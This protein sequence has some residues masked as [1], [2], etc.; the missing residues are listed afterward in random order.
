[1]CFNQQFSYVCR[2]LA[3]TSEHSVGSGLGEEVL[4]GVWAHRH[5]NSDSESTADSD[6]A[7][8]E[9]STNQVLDSDQDLSNQLPT[10]PTELP[11]DSTNQHSPG[12]EVP[13]T[14]ANQITSEVAYP[15]EDP[16]T[17]TNQ[18]SDL[19]TV[20][21]QIEDTEGIL[22]NTLEESSPELSPRAIMNEFDPYAESSSPRQVV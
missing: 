16:Q 5:R 18:L 6:A 12:S 19:N 9:S 14:L 20:T 4:S 17:L 22:T 15:E 2:R 1:M 7:D 3:P 13:S 11:S 21:Y 8:V 10:P